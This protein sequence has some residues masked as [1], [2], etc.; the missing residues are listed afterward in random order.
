MK[1]VVNNQQEDV[2]RMKDVKITS[3]F[4]GCSYSIQLTK[5]IVVRIVIHLVFTKNR[6]IEH[7]RVVDHVVQ[8]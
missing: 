5:F 4:H 1:E 7:K 3:N 2:K 8:S 6:A